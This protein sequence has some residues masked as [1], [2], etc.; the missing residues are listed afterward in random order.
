MT[1]I[2]SKVDEFILDKSLS[3]SKFTILSYV[4]HIS[5]FTYWCDELGIKTIEQLNSDTL[6]YYILYLR[7]SYTKS[8][9][10]CAYYSV[11]KNFVK[12]LYEWNLIAA[13]YTLNIH[14]PKIDYGIKVPV[15]ASE[16]AAVDNYLVNYFDKNK[17]LRNFCI[18]HLLLDCGFRRQEVINLKPEDIP[19]DNTIHIHDSKCSKSRVVLLPDFL[20]QSLLNYINSSG[21]THGYVFSSYGGYQHMCVGNVEPLVSNLSLQSGIRKLHPHLLRHTFG[22]SYMY[23]GGNLN[24]LQ[25]LMGHSSI[26]TTQIYVH[27]SVQQQLLGSDIYKLDNIFFR[28]SI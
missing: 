2:K 4:S 8:S 11:V 14:M 22:T 23:M 1:T 16:V 28:R 26:S 21:A 25:L 10:V 20:Q 5:V 17:A 9:T 3:C 24:M 15:T 12:W 27:L 7:D 13:D 18:F 19:G 6:R